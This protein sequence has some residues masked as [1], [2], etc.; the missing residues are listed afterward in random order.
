MWL[1]KGSGDFIFK[2]AVPPALKE[3]MV[4]LL[5]LFFR[6]PL[7]DLMLLD[8]V[9]SFSNFP[10]W[11]E[12]SREG[13]WTEALKSP[14]NYFNLFIQIEIHFQDNIDDAWEWLSDGHGIKMMLLS[15]SFLTFLW[16]SVPSIMVPFWTDF[17][18][19]QQEALFC[20]CSPFSEGNSNW[21]GWGRRI[22]P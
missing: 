17:R 19:W 12:G 2:G 11:G 7:L 6:K 13:S 16:F 22:K 14:R 4:H 15:W 8:N 5:H 21:C 1:S 20:S 18:V 10:F 9:C 3:V